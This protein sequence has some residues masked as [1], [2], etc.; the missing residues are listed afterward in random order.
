MMPLNQLAGMSVPDARTIEIRPWDMSQ[1][2]SIEKAILKSELGLTPANDGKVIRLSLPMLTEERRRDLTKVLH[3]MGEEFR[4]SVRNIRRDMVEGVKKAEKDKQI[5]EDERKKAD[6]DL[7][8][9]T[10]SYIKK[11]DDL[12]AIK[13]KE[14]MEV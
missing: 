5:T 4:V 7:Q 14:I 8:K 6:A 11:L 1:L 12:L 2:N 13:E 3:K 9:L 10:D